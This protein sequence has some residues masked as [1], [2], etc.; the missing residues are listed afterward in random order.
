MTKPPTGELLI[1]FSHLG[2]TYPSHTCKE[3]LY[4]LLFRCVFARSLEQ[5]LADI[6]YAVA[7]T[8]LNKDS[9]CP[10][11]YVA[12]T[13]VLSPD[14]CYQASPRKP[15]VQGDYKTWTLN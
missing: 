9:L 12:S 10:V 13:I 15:C 4:I 6:D 3:A 5:S 11:G 14:S 1:S 8:E 7:K 2:T